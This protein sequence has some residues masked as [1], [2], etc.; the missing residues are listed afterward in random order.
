MTGYATYR[1]NCVPTALGIA[2]GYLTGLPSNHDRVSFAV[3]RAVR[4]NGWKPGHGMNMD[5]WSRAASS[6]MRTTEIPREDLKDPGWTERWKR[7][8]EGKVDAWGMKRHFPRSWFADHLTLNKFCDK[9]HR[10]VYLVRVDRHLLC[11]INGK[12]MDP[13]MPKATNR[14][15]VLNAFRVTR[16]MEA[17]A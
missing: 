11:V 12:I 7:Q 9:Y 2:L 1:K 16:K 13:N 15:K 14:R 8:N 10:G 4:R 5:D 6:I 3:E 17:V